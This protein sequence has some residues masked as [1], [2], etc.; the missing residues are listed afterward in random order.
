MEYVSRGWIGQGLSLAGTA[1]SIAA[2]LTSD[3]PFWAKVIIGIVGGILFLFFVNFLGTDI[4]RRIY[5]E[6][7]W[8]RTFFWDEQRGRLLYGGIPNIV[9]RIETYRT[10]IAVF[11][12][13]INDAGQRND[14]LRSAGRQIGDSFGSNLGHELTIPRYEGLIWPFRRRVSYSIQMRPLNQALL[15]LWKMYDGKAGFGKFEFQHLDLRPGTLP[16]GTIKLKD[17]FLTEP[18]GNPQ[19]GLCKWMEGYIEGFLSKCMINGQQ[20]TVTS[21][22]GAKM[23]THDECDFQIQVRSA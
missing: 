4:G 1:A 19:L 10:T 21:N 23:M 18:H 17:S 22:C 7:V 20:V 11:L 14:I 8:A 15:D 5:R 3:V 9:I 16:R 12:A 6:L 13:Q 2:M